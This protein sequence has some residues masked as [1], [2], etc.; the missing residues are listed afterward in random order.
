MGC[1]SATRP[2]LCFASLQC[3]PFFVLARSRTTVLSPSTLILLAC[4][5]GDCGECAVR[6]AGGGL[7]V[8]G[9]WRPEGSGRLPA[10][11]LSSRFGDPAARKGKRAGSRVMAGLNFSHRRFML[12]RR[13]PSPSHG[14]SLLCTAIQCSLFRSSLWRMTSSS[15]AGQCIYLS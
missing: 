9:C 2:K 6:R 4:R 3:L 10:V 13:T 7:L 14:V 8:P 1:Q 12:A 5:G 15:F 11:G